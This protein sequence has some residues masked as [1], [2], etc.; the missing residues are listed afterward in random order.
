MET[1]VVDMVLHLPAHQYPF[2]LAFS[3]NERMASVAQNIDSYA[4]SSAFNGC[5]FTEMA[6]AF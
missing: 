3:V 2:L 1:H 4:H 5:V 6:R